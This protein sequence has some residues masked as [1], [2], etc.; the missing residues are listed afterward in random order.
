MALLDAQTIAGT[1]GDTVTVHHA[2][3]YFHEQHNC[4]QPL[5]IK[6]FFATDNKS[7]EG[8]A[9]AAGLDT[10]QVPVRSGTPVALMLR[11]RQVWQNKFSDGR[12][13]R[14]HCR[15]GDKFLRCGWQA[16]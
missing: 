11:A 3:Q 1:Q 13:T 16:W 5:R 7:L 6:I 8:Q 4:L 10:A 9:G 14:R 15:Y 12:L 2:V